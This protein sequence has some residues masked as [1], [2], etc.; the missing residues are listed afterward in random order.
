[1]KNRDIVRGRLLE[2]S[3]ITTSICV[4]IRDLEALGKHWVAEE[5]HNPQAQSFARQ[6]Q[7][8]RLTRADLGVLANNCISALDV[9]EFKKSKRICGK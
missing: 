8:M 2:V 1:M 7:Q 6:T 9:D 5:P 4:A 3:Q